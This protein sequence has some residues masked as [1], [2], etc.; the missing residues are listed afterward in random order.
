MCALVL[1]ADQVIIKRVYRSAC[2]VPLFL[3]DFN[4]TWIFSTIFRK[5][6]KYQISWE[7]VNWERSC[8][9]RRDGR[10][11]MTKLTVAFRN[12]AKAPKLRRF[13]IQTKIVLAPC[14]P[15]WT[16]TTYTPRLKWRAEHTAVRISR[17]PQHMRWVLEK[18]SLSGV[19]SDLW[20]TS[21]TNLTPG[22]RKCHPVRHSQQLHF[23]YAQ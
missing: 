18:S 4:E 9:T 6:H 8:S 23:K 12:A 11:D 17:N 20:A 16:E 22:T 19:T 3:S 7:T 5:I 2:K 1:C 15:L 13:A 14:V 10:T 21:S